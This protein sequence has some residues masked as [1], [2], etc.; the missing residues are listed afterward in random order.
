MIVEDSNLKKLWFTISFVRELKLST[1]GILADL[2]S[3]HALW[4]YKERSLNQFLAT[5]L[6]Q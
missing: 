4:S 5:C 6:P 3:L 1:L 2:Q